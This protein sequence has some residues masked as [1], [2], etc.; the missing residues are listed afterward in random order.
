MFIYVYIYI[1]LF[2]RM[3]MHNYYFSLAVNLAL[4][5]LVCH[6]TDMTDRWLFTGRESD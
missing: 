4:S 2:T 1:G 3:V 6:V 5:E